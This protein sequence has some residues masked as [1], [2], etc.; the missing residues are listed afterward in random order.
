LYSWLLSFKE[1]L[2]VLL[3]SSVFVS[4]K[5]ASV[6]DR[7]LT[8]SVIANS[9]GTTGYDLRID[10]M[11]NNNRGGGAITITKRLMEKLY[12]IPRTETPEK[13]KGRRHV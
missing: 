12:I 3:V 7:T 9:S 11:K 4:Q 8:G 6:Q 1:R 10:V 13:K 2:S 5:P